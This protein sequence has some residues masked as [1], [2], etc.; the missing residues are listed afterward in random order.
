MLLCIIFMTILIF[1]W[2]HS[3]IV[4]V[5]VPSLL[6][7]GYQVIIALSESQISFVFP[8]FSRLLT[9]NTSLC[10]FKNRKSVTPNLRL[11]WDRIYER[12]GSTTN[13]SHFL[14]LC[15]CVNAAKGHIENFVS[16]VAPLRV[17]NYVRD[18]I[19]SDDTAIDAFMSPLPEVSRSLRS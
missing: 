15:D 8:A 14:L 6:L 9:T 7:P 16:P 4:Y 13:P 3:V 2:L 12:M 18:A 1:N 17:R 19:A 10:Q 5:T 11:L